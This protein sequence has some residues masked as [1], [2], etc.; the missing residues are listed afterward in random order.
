MNMRL[1]KISLVFVVLMAVMFGSVGCTA[2]D[3][4]Q[5]GILDGISGAITAIIKIPVEN[6]AKTITPGAAT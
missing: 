5:K 6:W 1:A 2:D 3:G 4:W